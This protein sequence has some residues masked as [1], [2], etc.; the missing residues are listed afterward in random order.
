MCRCHRNSKCAKMIPVF[1][2]C[3]PREE[4]TFSI[5]HC[6]QKEHEH[7]ESARLQ[8]CNA[9]GEWKETVLLI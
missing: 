5:Y 2:N 3:K 9:Q 6:L 8:G 1:G 4:V 7:T